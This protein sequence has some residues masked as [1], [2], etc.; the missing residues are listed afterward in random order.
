[1]NTQIQKVLLINPFCIEKEYNLRVIRSGGQLVEDPI[2][3]KYLASYLKEKASNINVKIYDANLEAVKHIKSKNICKMDDLWRRLREEIVRFQPDLVGISCLFHFSSFIAH[4]ICYSAKSVS[5]NII[6]VMGGCYPTVSF[7]EALKDHNLDYAIFSEGEVALTKLIIALN[8]GENP[9]SHVDGFAFRNTNNRVVNVP[10][11][12]FVNL[13]SLPWPDRCSS[14]S[15]TYRA[16]HY[17]MRALDPETTKVATIVASR[18]CPFNCSFCCTRIFWGNKIRHRSVDD[19]IEEMKYLTGE[20]GINAFV[21]N[22]DNIS[23][24]K[25]FILSLCESIIRAKMN[26]HWVTGGIQ[27]SSLTEEVIQ[28]MYE[29]GFVVFNLG[30]ETGTR[31]TMKRIKKPLR[32]DTVSKVIEH[33]RK[34]GDGY[35]LGMFIIGF[36]LETKEEIQSTIKFASKLDLDW[37]AFFCFKP[38]PGTDDYDFCVEKGYINKD[39]VRYSDYSKAAT[40]ST[41]HFTP[42][43]VEN[44]GYFANLKINFIENRNLKKGNFRQAIKD[45]KYVLNIQ[46][47]HA[48]AHFVLGK[49]YIALNEN[50][51][52]AESFRIAKEIVDS[53][54]KWKNYFNQL[55]I[56]F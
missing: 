46:P 51:K 35:V 29:S 19:I 8:N 49:A 17:I 27:V 28:A 10:K 36:P 45:F 26:I 14:L 21:F 32:L 20:F 54:K 48:V 24:D 55:N 23:V 42:D 30:I 11:R 13:D 25:K 16:R 2:G 1:M 40:F 22:D 47:D 53:N 43:Y 33:I 39:S 50:N 41:E 34:Y 18:G 38:F 56:C 9:Q 5:K 7:R 12:K 6:T 37:S 31:D 52:A 4:R 15:Y 44:E 3:L